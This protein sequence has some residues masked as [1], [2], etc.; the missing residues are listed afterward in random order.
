M[1]HTKLTQVIC[2]YTVRSKFMECRT[3][4]KTKMKSRL[5]SWSDQIKPWHPMEHWLCVLPLW[6]PECYAMDCNFAHT[7]YTQ[8]CLI[9][10]LLTV[11]FQRWL[12]LLI[13]LFFIIVFNG[14]INIGFTINFME[15]WNIISW[16]WKQNEAKI[17][18][19]TEWFQ[20]ATNG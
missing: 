16:T 13:M 4:T 11:I 17:Q 3:N 7:H 14:I 1:E 6:I 2:R 9:F 20:A 12:T 18:N 19:K 10:F 5:M 8:T 15:N